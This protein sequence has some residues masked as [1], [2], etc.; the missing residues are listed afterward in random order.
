MNIKRIAHF[1]LGG[2]TDQSDTMPVMDPTVYRVETH[3]HTYCGQIVFQDDVQMKLRIENHKPVKVLKANI[4]RISI[5]KE[6]QGQLRA[7][8]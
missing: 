4:Q 7:T 1:I 8:G 5:V 3:A 6:L 2:L